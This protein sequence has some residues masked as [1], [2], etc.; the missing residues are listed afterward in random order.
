MAH[1]FIKSVTVELSIEGNN[2]IMKVDIGAA[3]LLMSQASQEHV[4]P[5]V[6]LQQSAIYLRTYMG[7][8]MKVLG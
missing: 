7:E 8:S 2:V 5:Q 6:T 1:N 3:V 4:F